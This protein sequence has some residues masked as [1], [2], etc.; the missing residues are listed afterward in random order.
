M[1]QTSWTSSTARSRSSARSTRS[2]TTSIR[3][4]HP[5]RLLFG[6]SG[7]AHVQLYGMY[8]S[9]AIALASGVPVMSSFVCIQSP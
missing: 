3:S 5:P 4:L 9:V 2:A 6:S 7:S 8:S 1:R